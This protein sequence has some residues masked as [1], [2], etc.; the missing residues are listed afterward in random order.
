MSSDLTRGHSGSSKS[1]FFGWDPEKLKFLKKIKWTK[2]WLQELFH[3]KSTPGSRFSG[4]NLARTPPGGAKG[5]MRSKFTFNVSTSNCIP[6]ESSWH[7]R[8]EK[9]SCDDI[10]NYQFFINMFI[11]ITFLISKLFAI[12][13]YFC[14][15]FLR[16]KIFLYFKTFVTNFLPPDYFWT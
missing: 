10:W 14:L 13:C 3:W 5:L 12:T 15:V 16:N 1:Q 2:N 9:I 4:F 11:N 6:N 8:T 7:E